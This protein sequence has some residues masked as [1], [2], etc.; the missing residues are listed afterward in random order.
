[1]LSIERAQQTVIPRLP[2]M[3]PA[4]FERFL[5]GATTILVPITVMILAFCVNRLLAQTFAILFCAIWIAS[6]RTM[7]RSVVISLWILTPL[8]ALSMVSPVDLAVRCGGS[9]ELRFVRVIATHGRLTNVR[10]AESRGEKENRDFVIYRCK[11]TLTAPQRAVLIL[12][13]IR[14]E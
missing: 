14:K 6:R 11:C 12:L 7:N 13:P 2:N 3:K 9:F 4:F 10:E 5:Q 8:L 1:M